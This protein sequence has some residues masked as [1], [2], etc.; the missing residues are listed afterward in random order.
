MHGAGVTGFLPLGPELRRF[1]D[2]L[3]VPMTDPLTGSVWDNSRGRADDS[4]AERLDSVPFVLARGISGRWPVTAVAQECDWLA[5]IQILRPN[6]T[7]PPSATSARPRSGGGTAQRCEDTFQRR[8]RKA[9]PALRT[10]SAAAARTVRGN[11]D[12][13][14]R[15]APDSSRAL[16]KTTTYTPAETVCPRSQPKPTPTRPWLENK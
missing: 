5:R 13:M 14:N 8:Q 16:A 10:Y 6:P 4:A 1:R 3:L 11:Q 2:G 7:A 12:A 9:A 15:V